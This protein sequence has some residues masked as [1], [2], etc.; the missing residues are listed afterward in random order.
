[1]ADIETTARRKEEAHRWALGAVVLYGDAL[2]GRLMVMGEEGIAMGELVAAR[3]AEGRW[4]DAAAA[5]GLW[6]TAVARLREFEGR[7]RTVI[8]GMEGD[9]RTGLYGLSVTFR[10]LVTN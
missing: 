10:P 7:E 8:G 1:L 5:Q 2:E 9:L 6:D 4:E 3:D